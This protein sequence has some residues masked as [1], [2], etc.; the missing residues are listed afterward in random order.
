[1]SD[2]SSSAQEWS[3]PSGDGI[4]LLPTGHWWDVLRVER[5]LARP[6]LERLGEHTGAV[7]SDP[8]ARAWYWLVPTGTLA[9]WPPLPGTRP[10]TGG[11]YVGVPPLGRVLGSRVHWRVPPAPGHYLTDVPLLRAALEAVAG[12]P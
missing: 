3:P 7:I 1:V 8:G 9:G 10:C 6:V 5:A 4:E 12:R 11:T 2:G